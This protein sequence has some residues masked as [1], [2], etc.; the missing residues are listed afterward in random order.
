MFVVTDGLAFMSGQ[1]GELDDVE[2]AYLGGVSPLKTSVFW[3]CLMGLLYTSSQIY[4]VAMILQ[5]HQPELFARL[6]VLFATLG[7]VLLW[8]V[9]DIVRRAAKIKRQL[10]ETVGTTAYTDNLLQAKALTVGFFRRTVG[11]GI[12]A[13]IVLLFLKR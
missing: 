3:Q 11:L 9:W 2:R 4:F 6:W 10:R 7:M 12:A 13:S 8:S 5:R 1:R